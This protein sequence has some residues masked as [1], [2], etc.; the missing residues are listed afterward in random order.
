MDSGLKK[1]LKPLLKE[2]LELHH[3]VNQVTMER[4]APCADYYPKKRFTKSACN[5]AAYLALREHD[6]RPLQSRLAK[7]G[8]SSLGRGG[9]H[10]MITLERVTSLIAELLK[11][12]VETPDN[13]CSSIDYSEG[14]AILQKKAAKLL[15]RSPLPRQ[16][17]IMV[18]LSSETAY[19]YPQILELI[20]L[21]VNCARINCAH[22]GK[23]QWLRMVKYIRRAEKESGRSCRILMDMAGHKIRTGTVELGA[24]VRHLKVERDAYGR[25]T[26]PCSVVLMASTEDG[27]AEGLAECGNRFTIPAK[28]HKKLIAGDRLL[29]HDSRGKERY[30]DIVAKTEDG[31]WLTHCDKASYLLSG[32]SLIWQHAEDDGSYTLQGEFN[33]GSF[34]GRPL[35]IRLFRGDL[36]LLTRSATPGAPARYDRIGSLREA[37]HIP[38]STPEIIDD[39]NVGDPLWIDDGKIGCVVE[40]ITDEGANLRVE[41]A[42]PQGVRLQGDKGINAPQTRFSLPPLSEKDL[43]DLDF[44]ARHA[45]MVGFSF[46]ETVEDMGVLIDALSRRKVPKLPII[47]KIETGRAVKNLPELLLATIGGRHPFGV[48]IARGDLSVE[49]GSVKLTEYQEEILWLCEAAHVPVIWATQVLDTLAKKGRPSRPEFTDAA[50]GN[51][52]ECVMLNKGPFINEAVQALNQVLLHMESQQ[53]KRF[54]LLPPLVW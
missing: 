52:A 49:V 19:D 54:S 9:G 37:A 33:L 22:D 30:L 51:R 42:A 39:L 4:L 12:P 21:G 11:E 2:L 45:D 18:T 16:T 48:M 28:W 27:S 26:A 8:F 41:H 50:M 3:S 17:R 35:T 10:V 29:F 53:T 6:L 24:A 38:C 43:I 25:T 32:N 1:S 40:G 36:L 13:S 31:H 14:P 20:A 5:L 44:I 46:V 23:E 47:V 34:P 7:I 15:G